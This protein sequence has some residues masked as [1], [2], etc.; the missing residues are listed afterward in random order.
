MFNLCTDEHNNRIIEHAFEIAITNP[1]LVVDWIETSKISFA[2]TCIKTTGASYPF[3]F[4]HT[5]CPGE[6]T[7][8]SMGLPVR[9]AFRSALS[10]KSSRNR[11]DSRYMRTRRA[12]HC[13]RARLR[14]AWP[15]PHD[16][17]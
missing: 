13:K 2:L 10:G 17:N 3:C 8:F 11:K 1:R 15:F 5:A 6:G 16:R 7:G 12:K 9:R 14:K 4:D